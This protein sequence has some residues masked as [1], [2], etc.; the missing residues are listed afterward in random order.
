MTSHMT[1]SV[2]GTGNSQTCWTIYQGQL[3]LPCLRRSKG[4]STRLHRISQ[5]HQLVRPLPQ[6]QP[7]SPQRAPLRLR[8]S[9]VMS[10]CSLV[11]PSRCISLETRLVLN[12]DYIKQ[13]S[14]F[15]CLVLADVSWGL[16]D[17][18]AAT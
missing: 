17:V 1:I 5:S 15:V 10:M 6:V 7:P 12:S 2:S 13:F 11:T 9:R 18:Q 8:L 14:F 4:L 3:L 16:I